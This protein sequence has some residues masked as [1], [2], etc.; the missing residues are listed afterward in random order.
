MM[1]PEEMLVTGKVNSKRKVYSY[2]FSEISIVIS[3]SK[4]SE[5]LYFVLICLE[6]FV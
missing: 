5:S 6:F 4:D 1:N 3:Q 2:L